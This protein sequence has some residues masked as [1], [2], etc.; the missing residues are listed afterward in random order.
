M[1]YEHSTLALET[2]LGLIRNACVC[3]FPSAET[4]LCY[5]ENLSNLRQTGL[6]DCRWLLL[7][8]MSLDVLCLMSSVVFRKS[9]CLDSFLV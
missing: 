8:L 7:K 2:Q 6:R 4:L 3:S 1:N 5:I 9:Y